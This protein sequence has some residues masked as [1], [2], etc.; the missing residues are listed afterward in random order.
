MTPDSSSLELILSLSLVVVLGTLI[1][2]VALIGAIWFVGLLQRVQAQ[3]RA[4]NSGKGWNHLVRVRV[5]V[6]REAELRIRR[7]Q[8]G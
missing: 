3:N 4:G 7:R 6:E 5:P 2:S 8:N 1:C